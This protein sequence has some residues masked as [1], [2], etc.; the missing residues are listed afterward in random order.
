M[1]IISGYA[2][3]FA[4]GLITGARL[5]DRCGRRRLFVIGSA[6]FAATSLAAALAV[7]PAMLIGCRL[8]QGAA[9]ALLIPQGL[10]I[11]RE[12]FPPAEL[13]RAFAVFGPVIG[14]SAVLG[15]IVGGALVSLAAFGTGWRLIFLV[16]PP[17]AIAAAMG[18][19]R[20]M[21]ESRAPRAP[22]RTAWAPCSARPRWA[23]SSIR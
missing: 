16:N 11:I 20:S 2:L 22:R 15:P 9:A 21:P 18:A 6:G 5:G 17:L 7:D 10:G 12:V 1:W 23:C 4:I 13:G 8:A 14:L 3:A 19:A